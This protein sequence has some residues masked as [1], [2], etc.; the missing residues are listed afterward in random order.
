MSSE[1]P[2]RRREIEDSTTARLAEIVATA[3]RAARQ[4][5]DEAEEEARARLASA[6][7]EAERIVGARLGGLAELAEELDAQAVALRSQ[8][9][10]L[11]QMLAQLKV[12]VG[13]TER[14]DGP[15]TVERGEGPGARGP[16]AR[17]LTVVG[18]PS[19]RSAMADSPLPD[20]TAIGNAA[21]ARLLATQMAVSGSSRAEIE[22]RL[23]EGFAIA[24]T[25]P[26][27]DAILGPER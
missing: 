18:D 16:S 6:D 2:A 15:A 4:V 24:D 23:R 12:D 14:S 13:S 20:P 22:A 21:G 5:I 7:A 1:G 27:L 19:E 26:I 11:R 25:G 9:E 8:A 10:A 17:T 3:E